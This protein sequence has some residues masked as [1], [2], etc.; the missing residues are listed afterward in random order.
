MET[1]KLVPVY[2]CANGH[3]ICK[4]CI[5][6]LNNCP[7]CRNDSTLVRSLKLENIVEKLEGIQPEKMGPTTAKLKW[8]KGSVRSYG[9]INGPN[10]VASIPENLRQATSRQ[11]TPRQAT[12]PRNAT[13]RQAT[14]RQA[15]TPRQATP[16]QSTII[17][18]PAGPWLATTPRQA[19]P[20]QATPRQA[21][22]MINNRNFR[23][24]CTNGL[25]RFCKF[26]GLFIGFCAFAFFCY[27]VYYIIKLWVQWWLENCD[28][29]PRS[30]W[31]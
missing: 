18:Q 29:L 5:E 31:C 7:I 27:L 14:P 25:I 13:P 24:E 17:V 21:T 3:V 15:S 8:G 9:T 16:M 1:I 23:A 11:A 6:K 20:R 2:Q 28:P 22:T 19:T 4:V 30:Q 12:I 10:R 26:L